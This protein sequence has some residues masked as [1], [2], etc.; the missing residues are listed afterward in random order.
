MRE[1]EKFNWRLTAVWWILL[2]GA[3]MYLM[4][5][6]AANKTIVIA[7]SSY[8]A[9]QSG[10]DSFAMQEELTLEAKDLGSGVFLIPLEKNTKAGNVVVENSYMDRELR[11]FIGGADE[12]FYASCS[13][14]GDVSV[15]AQAARETQESGVLLHF[16]M[17][18]IYE[19]QTSMDDEM[20][21]IQF[22]KPHELYK[23]VVVVDPVQT[24]LPVTLEN[25][26]VQQIDVTED[27]CTKLSEQWAME[28]VKL[29]FTRTG[30]K[31]LSDAECLKLVNQ[32][33]AD[34][35][36]Q[37]DLAQ[38]EDASQYGI[39][40]RY[41][42]NYFMPE[43]GNVEMADI[44]ARNV[45]IATDN[46][47]VG[48]VEAADDNLLQKLQIPAAG[49]ELGYISNEQE[50]N[51]LAAE[52]YRQKIADGVAAAIKEVYTNRYE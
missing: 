16:R 48:L 27:V 1:G 25:G 10:Q 12:Q 23:M 33:E 11:I 36:I 35:F 6:V 14:Q 49:V 47:A 3:A 44:V 29:Y 50:S 40:G 32:T 9:G 43:F 46:R 21:K 19:F 13:V 38:N 28:D 26:E 41:N 2:F 45:T 42:A 22:F 5:M 37:L 8:G 52:S 20:L 39:C 15:I 17:N 24:F 4:L 30:N 31:D 7:D 18:S 51:L 34:I